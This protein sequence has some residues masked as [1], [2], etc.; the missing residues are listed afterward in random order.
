M[1]VVGWGLYIG[2]NPDNASTFISNTGSVALIII[3]LYL[4]LIRRGIQQ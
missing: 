2:G 3:G 1:A 4:L